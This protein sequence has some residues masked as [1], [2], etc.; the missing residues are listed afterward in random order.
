[1]GTRSRQT[2]DLGRNS[3]EREEETAP[4]TRDEEFDR[5]PCGRTARSQQGRYATEDILSFSI[6]RLRKE[7]AKCY[8]S[9]WKDKQDMRLQLSV[10][11]QAQHPSNLSQTAAINEK[12]SFSKGELAAF[13]QSKLRQ[14]MNRS[15]LGT[16]KSNERMREELGMM[17]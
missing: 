14:E 10:H 11:T 7:M 13:S 15:G 17:M 6:T 12:Q 2:R 16:I 1:L 5:H 4:K 9:E 8:L 3:T